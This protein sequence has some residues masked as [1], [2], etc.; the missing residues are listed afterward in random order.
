[1]SRSAADPLCPSALPSTLRAPWNMA[2]QLGG[3]GAATV[4]RQESGRKSESRKQ[5]LAALSIIGLG[6]LAVVVLVG[7]VVKGRHEQVELAQRRGQ[8][9]ALSSRPAR[10]QQLWF[11]PGITDELNRYVRIGV[12]A[13]YSTTSPC[14]CFESVI[15]NLFW[16]Q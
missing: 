9:R 2:G 3:Y 10:L 16:Q 13:K 15:C 1:M 4:D 6:A 7:F 5:I 12:W 11:G 14:F 8:F